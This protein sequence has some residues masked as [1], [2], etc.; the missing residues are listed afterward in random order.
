M[1]RKFKR[2]GA[3]RFAGGG[4]GM[5]GKRASKKTAKATARVQKKAV[6]ARKAIERAKTAGRKAVLRGTVRK[7]G[8][9]RLKTRDAFAYGTAKNIADKKAKAFVKADRKLKRQNIKAKSK[10]QLQAKSGGQKVSK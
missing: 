5:A 4:G 1:A 6:T 9:V 7:D 2:D 3:G 8:S 10:A